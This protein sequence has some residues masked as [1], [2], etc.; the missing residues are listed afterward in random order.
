MTWLANEQD[1]TGDLLAQCT[2]TARSALTERW[3]AGTTTQVDESSLGEEDDVSAGSHG[4]SV[5]LGLDVDVLDGVGLDPSD[6]DLDIEVA[7]AGDAG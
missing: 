7:D 2:T 3:V 4:E 5:N 6:V 1:M